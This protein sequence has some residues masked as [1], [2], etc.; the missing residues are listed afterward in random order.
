MFSRIIKSTDFVRNSLTLILGSGLSQLIPLVFS[1]VLARVFAPADFGILAMFMALNSVLSLIATCYYENSI[2]LPQKDKHS[3][4]I[5]ALITLISSFV[6]LNVF[7]IIFLG[8]LFE[9]DTSFIGL[10]YKYLMLI[11][12]G[13]F[14]NANYLS[15]I[16]WLIRC[17]SY[18]L[19]NRA[20][21]IQS[22]STVVISLII[23]F[24]WRD[25]FG[26][27]IGYVLGFVFASYPIF[28]LILKKKK[29]ISIVEIKK[30]GREYINYPRFMMPSSLVNVGANQSPI[31]FIT[32]YFNEK[33]VGFFS[34]ALRILN[35]PI[36]IVSVSIGQIYFKNM[37]DKSKMKNIDILPEFIR[38]FKVLTLISIIVF[39]PILLLGEELFTFVFGSQWVTAGIFAETI[40]LSLFIRF[41]VTPLSTVFLVLNELKQ[42]AAW[43]MSYFLVTIFTFLFLSNAPIQMVIK[44]YVIVDVVMYSIYFLMMLL[45]IRKRD[46]NKFN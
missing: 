41:I 29:N 15:L 10:E 19:L 16:N 23:G 34:F 6:A 3:I 9:V 28:R 20:K 32:K 33:L 21:I 18:K 42:L 17:K 25:A 2:V 14:F 43:Q 30:I 22:S 31:Y 46:M 26:L 13:I 7:L 44:G 11:P 27:I 1:L 35:A 36:A 40:S 12:M 37:S 45:I 4:N 24:F 39:L 38:T 5:I 8:F